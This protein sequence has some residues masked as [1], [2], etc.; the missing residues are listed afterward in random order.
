MAEENDETQKEA[1][2]EVAVDTAAGGDAAAAGGEAKGGD[3]TKGARK[4]K[5]RT[6]RH[7]PVGIAH[8]KAT[9]NNTIVSITDMRG[10]VV[11]W[12]A[13]GRAGFKGSRKSTAF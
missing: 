13:A 12:S 10:G 4:T 11:A 7:V 1:A 9:F 2:P 3:A 5:T 6:A 8:I